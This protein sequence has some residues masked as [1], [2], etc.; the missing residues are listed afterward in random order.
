ML[1][2]V[3]NS[4]RQIGSLRAIGHN[5][6][7][8]SGL[9]RRSCQGSN[10][11]P[12]SILVILG[13]CIH[14]RR[15]SPLLNTRR[16]P[17]PGLVYVCWEDQISSWSERERLASFVLPGEEEHHVRPSRIN[18]RVYVHPRCEKSLAVLESFGSQKIAFRN[19][20]DGGRAHCYR[21]FGRKYR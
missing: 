7:R 18:L 8:C 12:L 9:N 10:L 13:S 6:A 20:H 15:L 17:S 5:P 16:A 19:C 3:S 14:G 1:N 21:F 11:N 4:Q 2:R